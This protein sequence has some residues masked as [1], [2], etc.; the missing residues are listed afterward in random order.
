MQ[1]AWKKSS[2]VGCKKHAFY[3]IV[4]PLQTKPLCFPKPGTGMCPGTGTLLLLLLMMMMILFLFLLVSLAGSRSSVCVRA[5][6]QLW[7]GNLCGAHPR[8]HGVPG[9][10]YFCLHKSSFT[11]HAFSSKKWLPLS[12]SGNKRSFCTYWCGRKQSMNMSANHDNSTSN[13]PALVAVL[14]IPVE[15]GLI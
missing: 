11:S 12:G 13:P 5:T 14:H 10:L 2:I 15:S 9:Y 4:A 1:C 6:N 3:S 7:K 8:E